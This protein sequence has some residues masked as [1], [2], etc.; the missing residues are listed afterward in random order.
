MDHRFWIKNAVRAVHALA[1]C[2]GIQLSYSH[3]KTVLDSG[4]EFEADYKGAGQI[5]SLRS[6]M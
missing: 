5:D 3:L 6:Y 1:V 2:G 4:K